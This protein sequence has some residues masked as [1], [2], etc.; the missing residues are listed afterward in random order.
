VRQ[1]A[2]AMCDEEQTIL[3]TIEIHPSTIIAHMPGRA[4]LVPAARYMARFLSLSLNE[5][6]EFYHLFV[7]DIL[8]AMLVAWSRIA[9]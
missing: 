7:M 3:L 6:N 1:C 5:R 9:S 4:A 8:A 2:S